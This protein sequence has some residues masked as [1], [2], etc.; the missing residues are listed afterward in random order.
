MDYIR[1]SWDEVAS[2]G[3]RIRSL[4]SE[5]SKRAEGPSWNRQTVRQEVIIGTHDGT[6][7]QSHYRNWR[8][9]TLASDYR[10]MYFE[11]WKV[12]G[13]SLYLERA[14]LSIFRTDREAHKEIEY[15]CLHCDPAEP[16]DAPHALYKQGPH[17]HIKL[18]EQPIPHSHIALALTNVKD[19][20]STIASMDNA[21]KKSLQMIKDQFLI[22]N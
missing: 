1:A 5:I 10:G 7:P 17:L 2:R 3:E 13:K 16:D 19:V 12:D 18:A 21:I 6:R 9:A 11:G 8:F 20:M 22:D 14:Y 15:V 4:L